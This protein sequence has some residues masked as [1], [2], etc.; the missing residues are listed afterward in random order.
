MYWLLELEERDYLQSVSWIV[1][2]RRFDLLD[3]KGS[4]F[5]MIV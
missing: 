1:N 2:R 4:V 5:L 3:I